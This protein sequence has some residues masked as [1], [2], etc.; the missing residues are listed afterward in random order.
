MVSSVPESLSARHDGSLL[1]NVL[2]DASN[3]Y[4]AS[5]LNN[6]NYNILI[7]EI[8]VIAATGGGGATTEDDAMSSSSGIS[9]SSL[10]N[11]SFHHRE[12]AASASIKMLDE[13]LEED[14]DSLEGGSSVSCMDNV[15]E[16][17]RINGK[18]CL[19]G[20]PEKEDL[21]LHLVGSNNLDKFGGS[22]VRRYAPTST[23]N[24]ILLS[25]V[26]FKCPIFAVT[27]P[28]KTKKTP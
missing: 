26:M 10:S 23:T 17:K 7:N 14:R 12:R 25:F 24:I 19:A 15:D 11:S 22:H 5:I 9:S 2:A 27:A 21:I 3:P 1:L 4:L 8:D 13:I 6:N 18:N 16:V 20:D 28:S